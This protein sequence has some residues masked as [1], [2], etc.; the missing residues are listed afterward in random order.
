MTCVE[1]F[2]KEVVKDYDKRNDDS[3]G[4]DSDL[5]ARPMAICFDEL[6]EEI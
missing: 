6:I 2:E 3:I 4:S 5:T 1:R